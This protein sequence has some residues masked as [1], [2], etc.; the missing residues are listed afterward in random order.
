MSLEI[1]QISN[2]ILFDWNK[3]TKDVEYFIFQHNTPIAKADT[4]T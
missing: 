3:Y 2:I 1:V 4:E